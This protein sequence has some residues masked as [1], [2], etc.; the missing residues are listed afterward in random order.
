VEVV[1]AEVVV[2][3]AGGLAGVE[4]ADRLGCTDSPEPSVWDG[5]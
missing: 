3:A 1:C 4:I 2:L 5:G